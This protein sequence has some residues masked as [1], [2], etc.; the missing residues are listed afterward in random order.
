MQHCTEKI[1]KLTEIT[2]PKGKSTYTVIAL[3]PEEIDTLYNGLLQ[4]DRA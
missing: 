1:K 4:D 3:W 2:I